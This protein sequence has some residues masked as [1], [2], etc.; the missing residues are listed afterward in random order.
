ME[1]SLT[2][3]VVIGPLGAFCLE[4][5]SRLSAGIRRT[6]ALAFKGS[7]AVSK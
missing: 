4:A 1:E 2:V 3:Q 5:F 7:K 6:P